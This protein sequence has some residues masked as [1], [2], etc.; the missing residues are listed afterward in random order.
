MMSVT[1]RAE[2]GGATADALTGVPKAVPPADT[3]NPATAASAAMD[4]R[5]LRTYT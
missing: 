1:V 3:A 5:D 4:G 2:P